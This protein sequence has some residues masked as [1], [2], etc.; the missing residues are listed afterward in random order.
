MTVN[1]LIYSML[2][3]QQTYESTLK[4]K[5]KSSDITY[6]ILSI[7]MVSIIIS[8]KLPSLIFLKIRVLYNLGQREYMT[9]QFLFLPFVG[10]TLL[11]Y[12]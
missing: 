3:Y 8:Q 4:L 12:V 9:V 2:R 11:I 5:Y 1:L 10:S 6:V 7:C